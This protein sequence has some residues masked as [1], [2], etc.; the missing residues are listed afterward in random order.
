MPRKR[1]LETAIAPVARGYK[2]RLTI[3]EGQTKLTEKVV[4]LPIVD[5]DLKE[6]DMLLLFQIAERIE[7]TV[8]EWERQGEL[9]FRT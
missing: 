1:N 8:R 5:D 6:I 3:R 9:S 4:Y 2:I 7:S